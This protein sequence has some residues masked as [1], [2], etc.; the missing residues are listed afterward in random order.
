[1]TPSRTD[2]VTLGAALTVTIRLSNAKTTTWITEQCNMI[3]RTFGDIAILPNSVETEF[4]RFPG[5]PN[6]LQPILYMLR[7]EVCKS[8][9]SEWKV[10]VIVGKRDES[11]IAML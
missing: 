5:F 10:L 2:R 1:M 11:I 9:G 3:V 8:I 4:P 6:T 7:V